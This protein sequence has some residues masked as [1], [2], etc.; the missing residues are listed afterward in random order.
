MIVAFAVNILQLS[1]KYR[2]TVSV[3]RD[4]SDCGIFNKYFS[5]LYKMPTYIVS[6]GIK[7]D[8]CGISSKY[9]ATL[10]KIPTG[11]FCL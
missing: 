6:V 1:V 11:S 8:D 9:F 7:V 5:T 2:R 4:I 3:C 10:G